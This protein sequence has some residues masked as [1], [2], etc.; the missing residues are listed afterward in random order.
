MLSKGVDKAE[1]A[2]RVFDTNKDGFITKDEFSQVSTKL[3]R[4][5]M[6]AVFAKFDTSHDGKL[7]LQE[8]RRLM[9]RQK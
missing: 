3:T 8:F 2:F 9:D 5:Q 7:S 1:A 6:D 4:K